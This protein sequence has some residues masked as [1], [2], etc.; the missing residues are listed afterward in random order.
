ML[1]EDNKKYLIYVFNFESGKFKK[2]Y[3]HI[4]VFERNNALRFSF[5]NLRALTENGFDFSIAFD[6]E[7]LS[8]KSSILKI[9]FE[10]LNKGAFKF[11]VKI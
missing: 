11:D 5:L 4:F 9:S 8:R 2:I 3:K 10:N 1:E 7:Y 6:T